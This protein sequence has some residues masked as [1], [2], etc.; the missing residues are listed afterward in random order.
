MVIYGSGLDDKE[1]TW[2]HLAALLEKLGPHAA[3]VAEVSRWPTTTGTRVWVIEHSESDNR[4]IGVEPE[5]LRLIVSMNAELYVDV[6][7]YGD[8]EE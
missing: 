5:Q 2:D 7:F 3:E 8:D 1:P 4:M 6:Y